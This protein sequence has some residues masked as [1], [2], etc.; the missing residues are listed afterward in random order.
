MHIIALAEI[1]LCQIVVR[2]VEQFGIS[3]LIALEFCNLIVAGID[4][5]EVALAH[6]SSLAIEVE[7]LESIVLQLDAAQMTILGQIDCGECAIG[8]G[9]IFQMAA[10]R[11]IECAELGAIDAEGCEVGVLRQIEGHG[12]YFL[13]FA[14]GVGSLGQSLACGVEFLGLAIAEVH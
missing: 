13:L 11:H 6:R 5:C 12:P 10:S 3:D 8:D 4:I 2:E 1:K 9:Q 7:T 14:G